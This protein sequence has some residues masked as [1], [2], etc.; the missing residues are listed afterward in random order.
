MRRLYPSDLFRSVTYVSGM[1]CYP[2]LEKNSIK[3]NESKKDD[4]AIPLY[5][6]DLNTIRTIFLWMYPPFW[7]ELEQLQN[8]PASRIEGETRMLGTF[9]VG[10][11]VLKDYEK[12]FCD[13]WKIV[14]EIGELNLTSVDKYLTPIR[15]AKKLNENQSSKPQPFSNY[16]APVRPLSQI[17]AKHLSDRSHD[18]LDKFN[19]APFADHI[20]TMNIDVRWDI[21]VISKEIEKYIKQYKTDERVNPKLL[22]KKYKERINQAIDIKLKVPLRNY[23]DFFYYFAIE[24]RGYQEVATLLN[25]KNVHDNGTVRD[26]IKWI[27]D[28]I[29]PDSERAKIWAKRISDE[30]IGREKLKRKKESKASKR[31]SKKDKSL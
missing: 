16:P 27:T 18:G 2:C 12:E 24:R 8:R 13:R 22:F 19:H 15:H 30:A 9:P 26:A 4:K 14:F 5:F 11:E 28:L 23:F 10:K 3:R 21:S 25:M 29:D 1:K 20:I 17:K 7:E 31:V 6:E